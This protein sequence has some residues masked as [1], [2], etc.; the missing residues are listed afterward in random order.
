MR[1]GRRI[2]K[3]ELST[4]DTALLLAGA[5]VAAT[6]Y[7]R[8]TSEEREIR[9]LADGLYLR[10]ELAMGPSWSGGSQS[11]LETRPGTWIL[12]ISLGGLQ[13]GTVAVHFGPGLADTSF[14][15]GKL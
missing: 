8:N 13:R 15:R 5:L 10:G 12:E 1:T 14:T 11:W 4:I 9:D 2:W 6:Y 3:C 7:D